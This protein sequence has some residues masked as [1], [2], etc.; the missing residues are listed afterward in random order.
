[1]ENSGQTNPPLQPPH[2]RLR[3]S[4]A[5]SLT[6]QLRRA[7]STLASRDPRILFRL[8]PLRNL[9]WVWTST[10]CAGLSPRRKHESADSLH[11]PCLPLH[12]AGR[13]HPCYPSRQPAWLR[14]SHSGA[15]IAGHVRDGRS[16][17]QTGRFPQTTPTLES[18]RTVGAGREAAPRRFD[19]SPNRA[20]TSGVPGTFFAFRRKP[21]SAT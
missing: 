1:M 17:R 8:R 7:R 11:P 14:S 3:F 4:Q 15:R 19:R 18:S 13:Q 5:P 12:A 10:E 20:R 9:R 6:L 16:N 2:F 21:R